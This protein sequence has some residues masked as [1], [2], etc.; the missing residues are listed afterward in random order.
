M[1]VQY[2]CIIKVQ[3]SL[4]LERANLYIIEVICD[5]H[6]ANIILNGEKLKIISLKPG[7]RQG[8]PPPPLHFSSVLEILARV[9]R[10]DKEFKGI[11]IGKEEVN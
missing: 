6:I 11:Q 4:G 8:C 1:K 3:E 7:R 2:A 5:K 10:Q 9:I